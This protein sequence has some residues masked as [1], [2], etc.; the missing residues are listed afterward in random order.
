MRIPYGSPP[1][2]SKSNDASNIGDYKTLLQRCRDRQPFDVTEF[3]IFGLTGFAAELKGINNFI[4]TKLN[5]VVY[6]EMLVR[7]FQSKTGKR[8]RLLNQREYNL[9]DFLLKET[10]PTDPFSESPSRQIQLSELIESSYV[11]AAYRNVTRRTFIRELFR[12][13]RYE[14]I[15]FDPTTDVVEVDFD[16]ISKY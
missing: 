4:K 15:K 9:L 6:R 14:F 7:A 16:A 12:L 2:R 10:E 11:Q 3:I 5:R 8:R 1:V 13:V